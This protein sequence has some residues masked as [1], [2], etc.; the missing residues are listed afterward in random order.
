MS[1]L[2]AT[3]LVL[4]AAAALAAAGSPTRAD[5]QSQTWTIDPNHTAAQFAVKHLVVSTVRGQFARTTGTIVW[6]AKDIRTIAVQVTIDAASV[7]T[8]VTMRDND[9]RSTNFFDVAT[10]PSI[11]FVSKSAEPMDATHFKLTGAL[12]IHAV[13]R[14]VVLDVEGPSAPL[15][16]AQ[17]QRIGA[18]ATTRID[19]HDFNL[20]YSRLVEG[21]AIVGDE[22][23]ITIDIEATRRTTAP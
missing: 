4:F 2:R 6:D 8:R 20:H 3:P 22:I 17:S 12:T 10:Y 11:T 19:R 16:Q 14:D 13:T 5:A 18:S 7:D 1:P 21:A 15:V 9:L 23:T